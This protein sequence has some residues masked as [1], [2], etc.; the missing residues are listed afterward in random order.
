VQSGDLESN[1]IPWPTGRAAAGKIRWDAPE[2]GEQGM[3]IAPGGDLS[4][5]SFIPG[6]YQDSHDAPVSD[7]NKDHTKYGDGTVLEYDRGSHTLLADLQGSKL[8][9]DRTKI[10][11]EIGA[12]KFTMTNAGTTL[13]TPLLTVT[14]PAS[15]FSGTVTISGLLTWL[16]GMAGFGG[17]S[18]GATINGPITQTGGAVSL[19]GGAL[20]HAGKNVGSTHTH[21]GVQT[22]SGTTG[23][24]S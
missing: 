10:E 18:S 3:M 14:A 2:V 19:A 8:T 11:F 21:T 24:P 15:T 23:A 9:M 7:A 12:T 1:W 13:V 6:V 5:A 4:Q 22:G 17:G 16:A 20:T